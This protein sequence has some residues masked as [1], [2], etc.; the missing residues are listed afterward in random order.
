MMIELILIAVIAILNLF[1]FKKKPEFPPSYAAETVNPNY[2]AALKT[3]IFNK[4]Y[5][6]L[7]S[8]MTLVNGSIV[9][10]ILVQ[11]RVF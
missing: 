2:M 10:Y 9:G 1:F 6:L 8:F 5:Q 11:G 4:N 7:F 3:M